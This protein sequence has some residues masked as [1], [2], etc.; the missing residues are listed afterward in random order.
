MIAQN[1]IKHYFRSFGYSIGTPSKIYEDNRA[2]IKIL[3]LDIVTHQAIPLGVIIT[4]L[5]ELHPQKTFE[6]VDTRSNMRLADLNSKPHGEKR[7]RD[8]IDH[9]IGDRFYPPIGS[10]HYKLLLFD[11][12]HGIS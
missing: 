4:A 3:L 12:V 8:L 7:L 1:W 2:K 9:V 10:E 11:Q 6:M 5:H